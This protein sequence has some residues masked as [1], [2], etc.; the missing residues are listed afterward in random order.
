MKERIGYLALAL[1]FA[2]LALAAVNVAIGALV[3][4][5]Q[6]NALDIRAYVFFL[7]GTGGALAFAYCSFGFFLEAR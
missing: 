5:V 3:V 1:L 6:L 2:V 7:L 4:M